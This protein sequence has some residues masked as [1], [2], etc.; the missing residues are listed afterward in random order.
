MASMAPGAA[1]DQ[2]PCA[3]T[4]AVVWLR[5]DLRLCDHGPFTAAAQTA[6]YLLPIYCLD[7]EELN[8]RKSACEGGAG[9]VAVGLHVGEDDDAACG[10]EAGGDV[11][12]G[13]GGGPGHASAG[14]REV[15]GAWAA[16]QRARSRSRWSWA[17]R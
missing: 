3:A 8:A 15:V 14:L 7:T 10:A 12:D 2:Q 11:G 6:T 9:G 17:T 13:V 16:C 5:R 4:L 1:G